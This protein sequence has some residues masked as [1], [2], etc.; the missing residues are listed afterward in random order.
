MYLV[1]Y[2]S[3]FTCITIPL[4][5]LIMVILSRVNRHAPFLF[6]LVFAFSVCSY[7][8]VLKW[9]PFCLPI[10][11]FYLIYRLGG[12]DLIKLLKSIFRSSVLGTFLLVLYGHSPFVLIRF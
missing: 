4:V 9:H 8:L 1:D 10:I 5:L 11:Y 3:H 6:L 7:R 12:S 2:L